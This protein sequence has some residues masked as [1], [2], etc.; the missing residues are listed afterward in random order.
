MRS[1]IVHLPN[2]A[3][4]LRT[5]GRIADYWSSRGD[6]ATMAYNLG[7]YAT[8]V[9]SSAGPNIRY[10]GFPLRCLSTVLDM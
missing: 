4:T 9:D 7:F 6:D 8:D 1:G 3:D 10:Y 5:L 2:A